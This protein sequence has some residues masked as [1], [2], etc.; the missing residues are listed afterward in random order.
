MAKRTKAELNHYKTVNVMRD[1]TKFFFD[2]Y[3]KSINSH[4]ML[5]GR[6][7]IKDLILKGTDTQRDFDSCHQMMEACGRHMFEHQITLGYEF[8][9]V[10]YT[11]HK[12][13]VPNCKRT[14]VLHEMKLPQS[15][16]DNML[17]YHVWIHSGVI[18]SRILTFYPI[19]AK[20]AV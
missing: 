12:D 3:V 6:E 2:C 11:V 15:V 20:D 13:P 16:W 10:I 9:G 4:D 7:V 17:K 1:I 19:T 14:D 5:A 18:H 8:D